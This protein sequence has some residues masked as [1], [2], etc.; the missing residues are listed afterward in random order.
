VQIA[1]DPASGAAHLTRYSVLDG[2]SEQPAIAPL[3]VPLGKTSSCRVK[4]SILGNEFKLFIND[5]P[6]FDWMD[7]RLPEGGVGFFSDGEDRAR[8][9]WVKV[10]P[11]FEAGTEEM[12]SPLPPPGTEIHREIRMGV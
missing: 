1:L 3:D 7:D 12:D 10:T 2:K 8:L 5:K 6:A 9:Y 4:M 11:Y